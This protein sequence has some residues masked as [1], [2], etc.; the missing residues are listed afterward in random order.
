MFGLP[1]CMFGCKGIKPTGVRDYTSERSRNVFLAR[2]RHR[3][4][5]AGIIEHVMCALLCRVMIWFAIYMPEVMYCSRHV[6]KIAEIDYYLLHVC[7]SVCPS[8]HQF[9][10][11]ERLG[12][13]WTDF[14]EILYWRNF[15]KTVE[16][17]QVL[18]NSGY[19][20]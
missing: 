16:V 7:P 19:F 5:P 13:Q 12:S 4:L 10:R 20:T 9:A 14:H 2:R 18:L 11:M 17:I 8:V 6:H 1:G 3:L 15:R